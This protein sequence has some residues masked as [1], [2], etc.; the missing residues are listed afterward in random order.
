MRL[1][2]ADE[3]K[4]EYCNYCVGLGHEKCDEQCATQNI[5]DGMA[6]IQPEQR[7]GE[8]DDSAD[9]ITPYCTVCGRTHRCFNRTPN[10]CP[11][12]GACMGAGND[13]REGCLGNSLGGRKE[14]DSGLMQARKFVISTPAVNR[15]IPCSEML[16]HGGRVL[17][18]TKQGYVVDVIF[19]AK[20]SQWFRNG[21]YFPTDTVIAWMPMPDAYEPPEKEWNNESF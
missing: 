9:G 2:D 11:N 19:V 17:A 10:F 3:L 8:W 4:R 20:G 16:P 15:W 21:E 12:C 13:Q 6:T 14:F 18:T 5:V 1:I 7:R